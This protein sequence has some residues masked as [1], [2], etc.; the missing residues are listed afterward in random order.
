MSPEQ[1]NDS[2]YNEKSDIWSSGCIIYEVAALRAPF[3]A[4]THYQ[5]AK[6]IKSGNLDRIPSLYSEEL[7]NLIRMMIS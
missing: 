7:M 2:K 3:E 5:L 6:K 1:I 4:T